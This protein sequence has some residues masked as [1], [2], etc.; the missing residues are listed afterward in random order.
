MEKK[1]PERFDGWEEHER[2]ADSGRFLIAFVGFVI[3]AASTAAL[4]FFVYTLLPE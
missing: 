4:L 3:I 2:E 1:N